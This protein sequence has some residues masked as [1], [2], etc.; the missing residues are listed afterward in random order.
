MAR[1]PVAMLITFFSLPG[2]YRHTGAELARRLLGYKLKVRIQGFAPDATRF[3]NQNKRCLYEKNVQCVSGGSCC[4][5]DGVGGYCQK[6]PCVRGN[7][8]PCRSS[9]Y[10]ARAG[11]N[12][13]ACVNAFGH[14]DTLSN[15]SCNDDVAHDDR[16]DNN[17]DA[18]R[19]RRFGNVSDSGNRAFGFRDWSES[20]ADRAAVFRRAPPTPPFSEE[21]P[22]GGGGGGGPRL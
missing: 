3:W 15:C 11:D 1:Q 20:G 16:H 4:R 18:D 10:N 14:D 5:Y 9:P 8:Q 19:P 7:P 13:A 21:E 2:A 22:G 12:R 17:A 6:P